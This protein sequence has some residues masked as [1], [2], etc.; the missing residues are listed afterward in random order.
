MSIIEEQFA[1]MNLNKSP[2]K[3]KVY[4]S[5]LNPKVVDNQIL[6]SSEYQV[7]TPIR[8]ISNQKSVSKS[9]IKSKSNT[10]NENEF[11]RRNVSFSDQSTSKKEFQFSFMKETSSSIQRRTLSNSMNNL[12]T[13]CKSTYKSTTSSSS[14]KKRLEYSK[15]LRS[16]RAISGQ[17][18]STFPSDISNIYSNHHSDHAM[19][20]YKTSDIN[21][22]NQF[23]ESPTKPRRVFTQPPSSSNDVFQRLYHKSNSTAR[24]SRIPH[25]KSSSNLSKK[26]S[27]N[28]SKIDSIRDLYNL[29]YSKIPDLFSKSSSCIKDN[30]IYHEKP[31][32][33]KNI[34][35]NSLNVYERGEIIRKNSIYYVPTECLRIT[36]SNNDNKPNFGFDDKDGNYIVRPNDHINYRY[37]VIEKIGNG[38]F[39]NV[40]LAKDNKIKELCGNL[41]AIKIINNNFNSSIQSINEIKMLKFINQQHRKNNNIIQFYNHF[42]F[43]SHICIAAEYLSL[44]L[45]SLMELTNFQGL[46]INLIKQFAKQIMNGLSFLHKLKIM[47]CDI[48]PENL[49]IKLPSDPKSNELIVKIIDFGSSCFEDEKMYTYIQSRFYR[50]P[51]IIIGSIYDNKI[52]IWSLGC[53]LC[54]LFIGSPILPGKNEIDQI[55]LILEI[56]GAPKSSTILRM[57][58]NFSRSILN[59]NH[60]KVK[61]INFNQMTNNDTTANF[62]NEKQIKKTLL[63]KIFDLNGKINLNILNHYKSATNSTKKQFKINSKNLEIVLSLN[64]TL[65]TAN[66]K[67]LFL[68]FLQKIFVWDPRE[69]ASV[70]QLLNDSFIK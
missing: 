21:N 10:N 64:N 22:H 2:R 11:N 45:Y 46:S 66:D 67:S 70:D 59:S 53:V 25:S 62:P 38:S 35:L 7:R 9:T 14:T 60:N 49:M 58:S 5:N 24:R 18:S 29:L 54:E 6:N 44:N 1:L 52:D 30:Q 63:Y 61:S 20:P 40:V 31:L 28:T 42:N 51:E 39:G 4:P 41:V 23:D 48:K 47:H 68:K 65:E 13:P 16:K 17:A 55:G 26:F 8:N 15:Q 32:D 36:G 50:A 12:N 27:S 34:S 33:L 37:Q 69:R 43:R 3:R 19:Q 57:R 56:F